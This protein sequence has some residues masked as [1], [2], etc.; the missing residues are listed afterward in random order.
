M[1]HY[2]CERELKTYKHVREVYEYMNDRMHASML[3]L[4]C[5]VL[6]FC[7]VLRAFQN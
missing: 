1:V 5:Y 4:Q 3:H 7:H 2:K 6:Y